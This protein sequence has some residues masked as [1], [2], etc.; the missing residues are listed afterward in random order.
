MDMQFTGYFNEDHESIRELARDFAV[1]TLAPIAG[2]IDK[3]EK[4]P[5]ELVGQ[6][7]ELGF[8]GVKIPEEY[9]GLGMDMRSYVCIMEEI[10]RKCATATIFISSANSLST[11]PVL[12]FGTE[13]Q[14]QTYVP[15][16]AAGEQFI[17]FGLTEPGAGSD[18]GSLTTKA[19]KDG[20]DYILNG[21]KC[22]I[23]MA[24]FS[25]Y[26]VVFAKTS[27]EKGTKG[28]TAFMVDMKL[29]G[30]SCGKPEEK[31]GQRGVAVSDVIL[32][33]VR[34]PASCIIGEVDKGF[35][36][37][38]KTLNVGR[39][40]VAS[41][42]LG[43]AAEAIDLAVEHTKNRVQFGKP[44]AQQQALRFMMADMQTRLNASRL[45]VYD[46]A[47]RM[48][49]GDPNAT[50]AASMAKYYA[51]E[52]AQWIIDRALQLHGGYGY[53]SEYAIERLYRD[54]RICSIYEGSSQ[55]QQIV[56]A[57]TLLK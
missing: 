18:A 37:A 36:N 43:M 8:L 28:I 57:G 53:S 27:P 22:F 48:D 38:M 26:C 5:M 9:G 7:A 29:P 33:D 14:K 20:D 21:R 10:S 40:G 17:A 1:N 39:I 32:E 51:A 52:S 3:N 56:I 54:I 46:A 15:G 23:S 12:L 55:V 49:T 34:V 24:P 42:A 13:E 19:V 16:V 30:V 45:L 11:E 31:M 4:F 2:E 25:D 50:V 35:T 44:L 6:M 41:M 47:Y